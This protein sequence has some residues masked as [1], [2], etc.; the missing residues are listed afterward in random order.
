MNLWEWLQWPAM[1]VTLA[2]S[3]YVT[4]RRRRR[5]LEAFWLYAASNV[6]W[7]AWGLHAR[8]Y[9]LIALQ[10]GLAALNIRGIT[11]NEA[12]DDDGPKSTAS[13]VRPGGAQVLRPHCAVLPGCAPPELPDR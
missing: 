10:F 8:A 7:I 3:W 6:L 9:A 1:G 12:L 2:A 5:R 4:S 13:A 11:H